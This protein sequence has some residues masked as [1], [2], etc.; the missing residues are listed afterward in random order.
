M[1]VCVVVVRFFPRSSSRLVAAVLLAGLGVLFR[2]LVVWWVG[3]GSRGLRGVDAAGVRRSGTGCNQTG[4]GRV[5]VEVADCD[6]LGAGLGV[7]FV[8]RDMSVRRR[9]TPQTAASAP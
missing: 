7:W 9:G 3:C 6:L 1:K 4:M 2:C 5:V 8:G